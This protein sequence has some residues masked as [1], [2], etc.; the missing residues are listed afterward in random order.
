MLHLTVHCWALTYDPGR[1]V[2]TR[3]ASTDPPPGPGLGAVSCF[4]HSSC[5]GPA[6]ITRAS[7]QEKMVVCFG[8]RWAE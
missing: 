6:G 7:L 8:Q 5:L 2:S 1:P 4:L 3:P